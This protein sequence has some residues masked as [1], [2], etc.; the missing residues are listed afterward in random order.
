[1]TNQQPKNP[2][3]AVALMKAALSD[4]RPEVGV[5]PRTRGIVVAAPFGSEESLIE[6][7]FRCRDYG[8]TRFRRWD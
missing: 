4:R 7:R 8:H 3:L 5:S 6:M 1:M 2:G